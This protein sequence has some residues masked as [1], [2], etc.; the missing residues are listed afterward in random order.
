M[1]FKSTYH[2]IVDSFFIH[3]EIWLDFFSMI[4]VLQVNFSTGSWLRTAHV[5]SIERG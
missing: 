4:Q 3:I 2:G 1:E 5:I